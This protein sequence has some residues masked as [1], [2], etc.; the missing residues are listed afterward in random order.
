ME[1]LLGKI[2]KV[3]NIWRVNI[4]VIGRKYKEFSGKLSQPQNEMEFSPFHIAA[5]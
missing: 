3:P 2:T 1:S 4:K 5:Q